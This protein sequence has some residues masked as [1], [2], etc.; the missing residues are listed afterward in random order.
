MLQKSSKKGNF[1]N[2]NLKK[3]EAYIKQA[4]QSLRIEKENKQKRKRARILLKFAEKKF[5]C[6]KN[7]KKSKIFEKIKGWIPD[8]NSVIKERNTGSEH[9]EMNQEPPDYLTCPIT[10]VLLYFNF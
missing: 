6:L 2:E 3:I 10:Y 5:S 1:S 7:N 8:K 4:K 9:D